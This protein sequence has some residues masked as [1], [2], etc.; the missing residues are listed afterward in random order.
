MSNALHYQTVLAF[1]KKVF[2]WFSRYFSTLKQTFPSIYYWQA[3]VLL[4]CISLSVAGTM[5]LFKAQ[6]IYLALVGPMTGTGA[7]SGKT[8]REAVELHIDEINQAGGIQNRPLILKIYDDRNKVELAEIQA[9]RIAKDPDILAV[10]GHYS[11][12][13][14][15]AASPIYQAA[16]I[17]AIT[18]SATADKLTSDNP[19]YFRSIFNNS[20][21]AVLMSHY[22]YKILEHKRSSI[23]Y[24]DNVFGSQLAQAY[25]NASRGV[26]LE[27]NNIWKI[28]SDLSNLD[29]IKEQIVASYKQDADKAGVL[30][31]AINGANAV[32]F[33]IAL[34][35]LGDPVPIIGPDSLT[36]PSFLEK[37]QEYP[38]ERSRPGYYTDG[39]YATPPFLTDIAGQ[40]AQLFRLRYFEKYQ[41]QPYAAASVYYDAALLL[42]TALNN[43]LKKN[44][45]KSG[46]ELRKHLVH[47]LWEFSDL[48]TAVEAT[49]GSLYF[50]NTGDVV[51]TI[52]VGHYENGL[53][54]PAVEQF[55]PLH[56]LGGIDNVL[57][58]AL[59]DQ[60]ITVNKKFMHRTQVVYT[61]VD[62]IDINELD[63]HNNSFTADF[64]LWF[65]FQKSYGDRYINFNNSFEPFS[66]LG[67]PIL[68]KSVP[69]ED[70]IT[71]VY[72]VKEKFKVNFDFSAYPLDK[73]K[74][75][76]QFRHNS[77]TRE[78]V[79]YV[80][81]KLG[82]D[83]Q[84]QGLLGKINKQDTFTINGWFPY[85]AL[86]FQNFQKTSST[87][88]LPERFNN[89]QQIAYSQFNIV[90]SIQR[91]VGG[92]ILKNLLPIF[93]LLI[94]GYLVYFMPDSAFS[95]RIALSSNLILATS[96]FHLKLA[97][98]MS[99]ISYF[100][101]IEY[102]F[103]IIYFLSILTTAIAIY[104]HVLHRKLKEETRG[105]TQHTIY[106]NKI[107]YLGL[108]GKVFYP[109]FILFSMTLLV[110]THT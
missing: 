90:V 49:T 26:G 47:A 33:I 46:A 24:L 12:N 58:S 35:E 51:N 81:D 8:M 18:A 44:P 31:M 50:S 85:N 74:L 77:L 4:L 6:P 89:S 109:A 27:I 100:I 13:T 110:Y 83:L 52:P 87:L 78:H 98:S 2:N 38:Q 43:V 7:E 60:I 16:A 55:Q 25:I 36:S 92:F 99:S 102:V 37:L 95:Q 48:D 29:E 17:L 5:W 93:F 39:I 67:D 75:L 30:Y 84:K 73:Q 45:H 101:L 72:R 1:L 88:G 76:I 56:D 103:Y 32:H 59:E 104:D 86:V 69:E 70:Y 94:L 106:Q 57:K 97:A 28:E 34:K 10:I 71:H 41:S 23:V 108:F 65:R 91:Y 21:Q 68:T 107:R 14:S 40:S 79:L 3:W 62:F 19:Y 63:V 20:D 11:S 64:Y 53:L 42:S 61:G 80:T 66:D 9:R 105:T 82:M 96:L 15:L 22:A 54:I